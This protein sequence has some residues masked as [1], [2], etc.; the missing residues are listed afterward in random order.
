MIKRTV[1]LNILNEHEFSIFIELYNYRAT[2][3]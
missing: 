1:I 3:L 2:G